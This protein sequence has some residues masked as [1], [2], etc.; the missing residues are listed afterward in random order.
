MT[1]KDVS[2]HGLPVYL[3]TC[4]SVFDICWTDP[5]SLILVGKVNCSRLLAKSWH[6]FTRV[7]QRVQVKAGQHS[8]RHG[9]HGRGY[10][11][12]CTARQPGDQRIRNNAPHRQCWPRSPLAS[13][14]RLQEVHQTSE[15]FF[16]CFLLALFKWSFLVICGHWNQG[17]DSVRS[18]KEE[19][20]SLSQE[21]PGPHSR[22]LQEGRHS[23]SPHQTSA[24][25][26]P[27]AST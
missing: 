5:R 16:L 26:Q 8:R 4:L 13:L 17:G 11:Q 1:S 27:S 7:F 25:S 21:G 10:Q 23:A 2:C 6:R 22:R 9:L 18:A 24:H 3:S 15:P 20:G 19:L 14:S 12:I